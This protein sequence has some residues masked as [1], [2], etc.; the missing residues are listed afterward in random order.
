MLNRY[1]IIYKKNEMLF[2]EYRKAKDIDE[3]S[4][5]V[6]GEDALLVYVRKEEE[7]HDAE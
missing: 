1:K 6:R 4:R 5:Y 7:K 3:I 2:H